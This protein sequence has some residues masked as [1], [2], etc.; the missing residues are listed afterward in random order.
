MKKFGKIGLHVVLP[1]ALLF[2]A[3]A[4]FVAVNTSSMMVSEAERT[5]KSVVKATVG[6]IDSLMIGVKSAA[7]NSVWIVGDH[8]DDPDY[9]YRIT[10]ELVENNEFIVGSAVAF[11]AG[12]FPSKGHFFSPYTHVD[13]AGEMHSFQLGTESNDYFIQNWYFVPAASGQPHWC[14][15]YFDEG[16]GKCWMSTYSVPVKDDAGNTYAILTADI[17]LEQLR[18]YVAGLRPYPQSYAALYTA[19]GDTLVGPP[20]GNMPAPGKTITI[21]DVADNGWVVEIVCPMSEILKG[22]Q[23]LVAKIIVFSVAGLGFI[24]V[25]SWFYSSRLQ[26]VTASRERIESELSIASRIQSG[27]ISKNF[28]ACLSADIRPAREVG[29]DL[30]DFVETADKLFFVVGDASGK[31]VP[32]ALFSFMAG[33]AFRFAC[34]LG[35]RPA[36]IV[37][38]VNRMLSTGNDCCMFVTIF[39]GI[40]DKATG[41]LEYCNAGHNPPVMVAHGGAAFLDV[42]RNVPAGVVEDFKFAEQSTVLEKGDR[43]VVYT[44]GVTEAERTDH[45]AFGN[46]RLL[47][48]VAENKAKSAKEITETLMSAVAAFTDG[49]EQSDDITV[50]SIER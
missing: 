20:R 18:G 35:M 40:L 10:R 13:P 36:E 28:P 37:G 6:R 43:L 11:K 22:A 44:D 8:L 16:G 17:S 47:A 7:D 38:H 48:L 12:F 21:R 25:L 2:S 15:P 3:I 29:G 33:T 50:L 19:K 24:F 23:R 31:G 26:R 5:V 32:A 34:E 1:S 27:F 39:A 45:S 4:A 42:K 30:Y 14:E 41:R 9:M 46:D 49:A